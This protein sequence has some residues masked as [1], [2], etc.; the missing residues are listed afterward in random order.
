MRG[1]YHLQGKTRTSSWKIK[2]V[3]SFRLEHFVNHRPLVGEIKLFAFF[4][5]FQSLS[6]SSSAKFSHGMF[7]QEISNQMVC[8]NGKYP[9]TSNSFSMQVVAPHYFNG[10]SKVGGGGE[11]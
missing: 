6:L 4:S 11:R 3:T 9:S 8:V 5:V 1:A 7:M 10:M 2:W